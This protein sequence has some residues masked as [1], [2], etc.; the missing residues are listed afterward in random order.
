MTE[1]DRGD[2]MTRHVEARRRRDEAPLDSSAYRAASEEVADI[3]IAIA[4]A[5]EPPPVISA[6]AAA[7]APAPS[8]E[9]TSG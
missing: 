7:A 8:S 4:A 5:E 2:L 1:R 3:E 9:R 6:P